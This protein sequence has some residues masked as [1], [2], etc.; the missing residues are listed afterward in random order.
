[1]EKDKNQS[2]KTQS[3]ANQVGAKNDGK[4]PAVWGFLEDFI[5]NSTWLNALK[6]G[7]SKK[8]CN[9][10]PS[11]TSINYDA[12]VSQYDVNFADVAKSMGVNKTEHLEFYEGL[13][14]LTMFFKEAQFITSIRS[15]SY[16]FTAGA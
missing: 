9:C 4:L 16:G 2:G 15:E 5:N 1:M 7:I 10:L 14:R 8:S 3:G 12:E 13:S 6:T 11:C